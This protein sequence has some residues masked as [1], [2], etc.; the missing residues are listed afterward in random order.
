MFAHIRPSAPHQQSAPN[1][2]RPQTASPRMAQA[3]QPPLI[4]TAHHGQR[5]ASPTASPSSPTRLPT[6]QKHLHSNAGAPPNRI[7][8][9]PFQHSI[10]PRQRYI[11]A[12]SRIGPFRFRWVNQSVS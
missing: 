7:P 8:T 1:F 10:P 3:R 11:R 2:A 12:S 5:G 4:H 6:P 9:D